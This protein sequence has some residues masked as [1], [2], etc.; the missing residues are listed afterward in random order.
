MLNL[1][2][3]TW[4]IIFEYIHFSKKHAY[5]LNRNLLFTFYLK[6][7]FTKLSTIYFSH[8][9]FRTRILQLRIEYQ[10]PFFN[11]HWELLL[12]VSVHSKIS[13]NIFKHTIS[14]SS[15]VKTESI[16]E[17]TVCSNLSCDT[18]EHTD[19]FTIKTE[20]TLSYNRHV[21]PDKNKLT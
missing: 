15:S 16:S 21:K 5:I 2:E 4:R 11:N 12:M 1:K 3:L 19:T 13:R 14:V 9:I 17:E 18:F 10:I 7:L 6:K 8:E 20:T